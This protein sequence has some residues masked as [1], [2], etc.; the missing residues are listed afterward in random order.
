MRKVLGFLVILLPTMSWADC[1]LN[2]QACEKICAVKHL[3]DDA[4]ELGCTSRCV[5]ERAACLAEQGADK[6]VE[7][8]N[9]VVE[10]TK[11][12]FSGMKKD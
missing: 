7:V 11:S 8:G 12:F 3:T 4:A 5:A 6:A 2:Y 9:S 1:G 10:S